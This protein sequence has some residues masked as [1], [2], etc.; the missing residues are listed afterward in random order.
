MNQVYKNI[1]LWVVLIAFSIVLFNAFSTPKEDKR[2]INYSDFV[3]MVEQGK[4]SEVTIQENNIEGKKDD[5]TKF[6]TYTPNDSQLIA[7]LREKN[8]RI[9]AEP[10]ATSP[11]YLVFL[12]SWFPLLVLL[13]IWIFF[14]RQMQIGG[15]KALSFGKSKAKLLTESQHKVTFED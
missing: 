5:G 15:N 8:V 3:K 10:P 14:M 1:L 2:K 9:A 7:M 12:S 11:W 6:K 4:V 13:G